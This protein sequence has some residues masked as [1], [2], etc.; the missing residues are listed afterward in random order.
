MWT[1]STSPT[2]STCTPT[3]R[4]RRPLERVQVDR[5]Q[6]VD[7]EGRTRIETTNPI[8]TID[9]SS[10]ESGLFFMVIEA[11]GQ[12]TVKSVLKQ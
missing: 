3:D 1:K 9:L 8:N 7:T 12:R 5:L 6:V 11:E 4:G 10:L 2:S